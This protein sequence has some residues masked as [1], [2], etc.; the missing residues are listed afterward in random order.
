MQVHVMEM[1]HKRATSRLKNDEISIQYY[2]LPFMDCKKKDGIE[3]PFSIRTPI[4]GLL[5]E[6]WNRIPIQHKDSHSRRR[7]AIQNKDSHSW[8]ARRW[9]SIKIGNIMVT[10]IMYVKW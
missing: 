9:K 4:H 2:R 1:G 3:L 8:T 6:G 7:T 5:E 10:E